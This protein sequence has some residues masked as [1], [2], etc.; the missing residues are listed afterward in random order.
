MA[1]FSNHEDVYILSKNPNDGRVDSDKCTFS[2]SDRAFNLTV[3]QVVPILLQYYYYVSL[4]AKNPGAGYLNKN[5]TLLKWLKKHHQQQE[6]TFTLSALSYKILQS[7]KTK[8]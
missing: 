5:K 6:K 2:N 8:C 3:F 4:T 7:N 1:C